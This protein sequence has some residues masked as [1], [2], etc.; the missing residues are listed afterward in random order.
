MNGLRKSCFLF[1]GSTAAFGAS[2]RGATALVTC[3][4][5]PTPMPQQPHPMAG[6]G[7]I[8]Q[9][10]TSTPDGMLVAQAYAHIYWQDPTTPGGYYTDHYC[11]RQNWVTKR[12]ADSKGFGWLRIGFCMGGLLSVKW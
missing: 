5:S 2:Y 4:P 7:V 6:I 11:P 8:N 9:C 10:D 12:C 3:L 1:L